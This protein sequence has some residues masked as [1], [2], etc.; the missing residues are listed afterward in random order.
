MSLWKPFEDSYLESVDS[1]TF[2]VTLFVFFK[3]LMNRLV[4]MIMGRCTVTWL[5]SWLDLREK[6]FCGS[7]L[8]GIVFYMKFNTCQK[9]LVPLYALLVKLSVYIQMVHFRRRSAHQAS[10]ETS[11]R[12]L[13]YTEFTVCSWKTLA[14]IFRH[15]YFDW[16]ILLQ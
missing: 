4:Y 6:T 9:V 16:R 8:L 12:F 2:Q 10:I 11:T 5:I 13:I 1:K 15:K 3:C 14:A 7:G